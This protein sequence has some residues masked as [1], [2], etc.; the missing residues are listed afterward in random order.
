MAKMFWHLLFI[1]SVAV[2]WVWLGCHNTSILANIVIVL[3]VLHLG[4]VAH[5]KW[6]K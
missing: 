6:P 5:A 1:L 3:G 2:G 4:T